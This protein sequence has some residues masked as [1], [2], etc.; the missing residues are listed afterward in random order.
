[1]LE[2]IFQLIRVL[3]LVS[4][5]APLLFIV[6]TVIGHYKGARFKRYNPH[7]HKADLAILQIPT[8]GNYKTVNKIF[9]IVRKYAL[10]IPLQCWVVIEEG[11]NPAKY[12]AD[13]II[14]VPKSFK[15]LAHAKARALEYARRE[16]LRLASEG[17]IPQKYVVIQSDDDSV[18]SRELILEALTVDADIIIGTIKP[19]KTTPLGLLLDY[20]RPYT[21]I[22]TCMFFTN[23]GYVLYGH[24]ESQIHYWYVEEK[25]D[26]E[27]TPL[28][29]KKINDVPV[30]GNEDMYFIHKAEIA[31]FKVFKSEK[32]VLI[33]PPL[34]FRDAIKQRRRWLWGN[35]N[36]VYIKRMLP[37]SHTLRFLFTHLC[38]FVFYP[39]AQ[40]GF[41]ASLSGI[42][43]LTWIEAVFA[44]ILFIGW[45][46]LRFYSI[47]KVMG[48]KHGLIGTLVTKITTFLNFA[49]LSI[50]ALQGDPKRFE[51]IKK[52]L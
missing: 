9:S 37:I 10:P 11:D 4:W 24:G 33:C 32:T 36:I 27:F 29:G 1:M 46:G 28:N 14:V 45:Y 41:I 22:H 44:L 50:G 49:I 3:I 6:Q 38:A 47:T 15:C 7:S 16:R 26:Y 8:V 48:L 51:V 52:A 31:G 39:F 21:C 20:E 2:I 13:R 12:D 35:F 34:T 40:L 19:R 5:F 18:M 23:L 30:M 42:M 43:R 25:L 17:V